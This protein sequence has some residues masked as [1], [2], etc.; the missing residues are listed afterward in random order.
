MVRFI[1]YLNIAPT[2]ISVP[3]L[4]LIINST[5]FIKSI[6]VKN[7][8]TAV[9]YKQWQ[10]NAEDENHAASTQRLMIQLTYDRDGPRRGVR[11]NSINPDI[12]IFQS[13]ICTI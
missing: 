11:D 9:E 10:S 3:T 1:T 7:D 6:V 12:T 13:H 5:I 8:I 4:E 2:A